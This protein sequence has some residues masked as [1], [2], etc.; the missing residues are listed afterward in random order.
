MLVHSS[1]S[2]VHSFNNPLF[3]F[4]RHK[5]LEVCRRFSA[6]EK[7]GQRVCIKCFVKHGIECSKTLET[8]TVTHG[9]STLSKKSVYKWCKLFQEGRGDVNDVSRPGPHNLRNYSYN[10]LNKLKL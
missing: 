2:Y 3:V 8:F 7:I 5:R 6:I 4:E 9:E 1:R 10:V